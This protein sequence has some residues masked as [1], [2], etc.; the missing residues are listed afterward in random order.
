M[1]TA[2]GSVAAGEHKGLFH[3]I[4]GSFEFLVVLSLL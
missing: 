4:A 3:E 1:A 2:D